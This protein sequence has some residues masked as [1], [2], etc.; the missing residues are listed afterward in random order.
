MAKYS[1]RKAYGDAEGPFGFPM[2]SALASEIEKVVK[3]LPK[4]LKDMGIQRRSFI[5]EAKDLI[6]GERAD[7]SLITSDAVDRDAEV[8]LPKGGNWKQFQKNPVVTFAH[9]Y[10]ELPVGRALWVKRAKDEGTNGWIAKTQYTSRPDGWQ[11]PWFPDA[12]WHLIKTGDLRGKSIGFLITDGSPPDEKEIGKRPELSGVRFVIRKWLALE[13][14]VAP[15]QSNPE[16]FVLAAAKGR[17]AGL[18]METILTESGL[19][20]PMDQPTFVDYYKEISSEEPEP[21][22]KPKA[23]PVPLMTRDTIRKAL[24]GNIMADSVEAA[25]D[26][27]KGRV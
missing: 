12:V 6:E 5:A 4:H 26:R 7:I 2:P 22:R 9:K 1:S 19:I 11:G 25:V 14:A 3:G 24:E 15:V 21:K 27:L 13:Y 23:K 8:M 10:D 17:E 18:P 20:L 16:A